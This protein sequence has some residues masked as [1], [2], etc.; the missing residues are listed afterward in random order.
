[1]GPVKKPEEIE[2]IGKGG[3]ILAG[4]LDI[5][6]E[7]SQAGVKTIEL[8]RLAEKMIVEAG[9]VPSFKNYKGRPDE[10]PFPSTICASVNN[11]LVH[12]P[13]SDYELKD[14]DIFTID[15]GMRY[16]A[17]DGFYTD[18]ARTKA[19]GKVSPLARKLIKI[20]RES[21]DKGIAVAK[22]GNSISDISKAV[23][24]HAEAAGFGV[25]RDLVGHGVGYEIHE[26][27]RVPNY[28]DPSHKDVKLEE[29]MVL[30][31]EPMLNVG[32]PAIKTKKDGWAIV[33]AD[34]SLCAH[35]ENTVVVRKDSGEVLTK[36]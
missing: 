31:I 25:V 35:F 21:L 5:L 32:D 26:D 3:K 18:M 6:L 17:E 30:A 8:D 36:A 34:G 11:E 23:Q 9:G 27:P 28:F 7:K 15:I 16:P 1:M 19:I 14:G 2:M 12:T 13:A 22:T 10:I 33:A 29:G 4:I 24:A 20:T